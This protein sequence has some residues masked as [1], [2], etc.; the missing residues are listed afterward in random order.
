MV[1]VAHAAGATDE[2]INMTIELANCENVMLTEI[3]NKK[4]KRRDV[5]QTMALALKSSEANSINWGKIG[6]AV[7]DRWS[8]ATWVWIKDQAWSGK[9][10]EERT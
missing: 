3:A 9:C 4:C 7:I 2:R 5:A 1:V 10:F 6:Q 8:L